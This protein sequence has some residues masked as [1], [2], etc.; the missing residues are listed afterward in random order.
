MEAAL[1]VRKEKLEV[2]QVRGEAKT[3]EDYGATFFKNI[4]R[5]PNISNNLPKQKTSAQEG[6]TKEVE[7]LGV[8]SPSRVWLRCLSERWSQFQIRLQGE[9]AAIGRLEE[10][11]RLGQRVLVRYGGLVC[12]ASVEGTTGTDLWRVR[13]LDL[14]VREEVFGYQLGTLKDLRLRQAEP[15]S[16][17]V[18]VKGI[19]PAGGHEWS[20]TARDCLEHMTK[21]KRV[22]LMHM[23]NINE[24]ALWVAKTTH[25]NPVGLEE[26]VWLSVAEHLVARGLAFREGT[27][28]K[29]LES[30]QAG[31]GVGRNTKQNIYQ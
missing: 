22:L 14:G 28:T 24:A 16:F 7:V 23:K 30:C 11:V 17:L 26:E 5:V 27:K 29:V 25:D 21:G 3:S 1:E 31:P 12:R 8:E 15:F 19:E 10:E 18:G 20:L 13:L 4:K 9:G 2:K 6:V